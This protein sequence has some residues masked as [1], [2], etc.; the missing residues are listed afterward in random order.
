ML[1]MGALL[2]EDFAH[3]QLP[4]WNLNQ[5]SLKSQVLV[6]A[7]VRLLLCLGCSSNMRIPVFCVQERVDASDF[8]TGYSIDERDTVWETGLLV[9]LDRAETFFHGSMDL[10][11]CTGIDTVEEVL[12]TTFVLV[13][14]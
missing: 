10:F 3:E 12:K 2:K 11:G 9:L 6:A 1:V 8:G 7:I 4:R 13:I 5:A 14:R